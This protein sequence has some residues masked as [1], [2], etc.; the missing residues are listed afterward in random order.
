MG[1]GNRFRQDHAARQVLRHFAG[2]QVALGRRHDGILVAVLLHD[3]LV[4]V[5]DEGQDGFV[6][7]VG[8]A[9]QG[10]AVAVDD[11][12]LRQFE[13]A[14]L[15]ELAF[16]HVLDVFHEQAVLVAPLHV[17]RNAADLVLVQPFRPLHGR[18]GLADGDDDLLQV[19]IDA[20]AV[21]FDDFRYAHDDAALSATIRICSY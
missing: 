4:V 14:G 2:D 11:V 20:G 9:H 15:L 1:L 12:G 7:R 17:F 16:H 13:L 6:R 18:V 19:E 3:I 5:A 21:P 8:F 10:P